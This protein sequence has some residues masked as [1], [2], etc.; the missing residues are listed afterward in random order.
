MSRFYHIFV[1]YPLQQE[2]ESADVS[3]ALLGLDF[4]PP[5]VFCIPVSTGGTRGALKTVPGVCLD[6]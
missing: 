6:Y 3:E 1:F 5:H 4:P 2:R